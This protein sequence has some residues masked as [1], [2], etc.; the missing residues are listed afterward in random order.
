MRRLVRIPLLNVCRRIDLFAPIDEHLGD[1]VGGVDG[2][3]LRGWRAG[4]Q[5]K[6]QQRSGVHLPG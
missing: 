1:L 5:K 3:T 4:N 6:T 2:R